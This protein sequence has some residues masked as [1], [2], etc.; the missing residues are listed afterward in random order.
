MFAKGK[1]NF[2]FIKCFLIPP[3]SKIA[4]IIQ[5]SSL[6]AAN[7]LRFQGARLDHVSHV[8]LELVSFVRPG[9][10]NCVDPWRVT[11]SCPIKK[12]FELGGITT[13]FNSYISNLFVSCQ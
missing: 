6:F 3:N 12:A 9:E 1:Q 13:N 10:L 2:L 11:R 5:V 8:K 4:K 7:L